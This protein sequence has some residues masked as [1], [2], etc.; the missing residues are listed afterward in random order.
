MPVLP[1]PTESLF[2]T[3]KLELPANVAIISVSDY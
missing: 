2:M 1:I 3:F